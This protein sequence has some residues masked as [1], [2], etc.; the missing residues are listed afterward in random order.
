MGI[1]SS[2]KQEMVKFLTFKSNTA[3]AINAGASLAF[4]LQTERAT[5]GNNLNTLV[6]LN[7]S[8]V[9]VNVYLD[10][11]QITSVSASNG[12]FSIDWKDGINFNFLTIQNADGAV[13]CAQNA[14]KITV[15]R[16]GV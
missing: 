5:Y 9:I 3:A 10:G 7:T 8:A 11:T 16:T 14:L 6:V 4:D 1:E 12:S 15:G 13:A 2:T